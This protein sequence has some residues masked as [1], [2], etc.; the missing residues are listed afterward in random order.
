VWKTVTSIVSFSCLNDVG[1]LKVEVLAH[2]LRM[3]YRSLEIETLP[4][5]V[6]SHPFQLMLQGCQ[7]ALVTVDEPLGLAAKIRLWAAGRIQIVT[8]GYSN[9]NAVVSL[10]NYARPGDGHSQWVRFPST[11]IPSF[12][13]MNAEIAGL[14]SSVLVH[15]IIGS[16]GGI[17]ETGW[18]VFGFPREVST[19]TE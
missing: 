1:K 7:G 13:P 17:F 9:R 6:D 19:A 16:L 15:S 11:I 14:A 4:V 3:R 10:A 12:G 2:Q 5:D 8:A 18:N